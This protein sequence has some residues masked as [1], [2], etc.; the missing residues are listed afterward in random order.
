MN[1]T[2]PTL[3]GHMT[4]A[5]GHQVP[6]ALVKPLD[7]L[8]DQLVRTAVAEAKAL[9]DALQT[10]KARWLAETQALVALAAAEY[11]TTLGG[12]KGNLTLRTFDGLMEM[13]VQ[14]A[15]RLTFDERLKVA[16]A[17]VGECLAEWSADA[18]P[19]LKVIV[20]RAFKTDKEGNVSTGAVLELRRLEIA[21]DRW[22]R[23]M[24]AI[25]DALQRTGTATY[26]RFYERA[27]M[28]APSVAI[29]LDLA[30]L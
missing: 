10:F 5:Q 11:E 15:D 29:S 28:G 26:L 8:R 19:E 21:D 12:V 27:G 9:R 17:L 24:D 14:V 25:S 18:R 16:E 30:K 23:A 7:K 4:N 13:T 2:S 3:E 20:E 22:K 6:A 1:A